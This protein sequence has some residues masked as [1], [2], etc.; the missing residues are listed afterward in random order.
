MEKLSGNQVFARIGPFANVDK[1]L[2]LNVEMLGMQANAIMKVQLP[3]K[4][5]RLRIKWPNAQA[6]RLLLTRIVVAII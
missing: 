5:G 4:F 1:L 2:A 3:S 6:V